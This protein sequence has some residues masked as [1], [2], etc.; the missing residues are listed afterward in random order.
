MATWARKPAHEVHIVHHHHRCQKSPAK[1]PY[2]TQKRSDDPAKEPY[3]SQKRP[4]DTRTIVTTAPRL[5]HT[6]LLL[7]LL[8]PSINNN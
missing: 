7:L 1:E 2:E 6:R 3:E 5:P 8:L 4:N